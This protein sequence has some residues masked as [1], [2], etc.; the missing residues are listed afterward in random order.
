MLLLT[1]GTV[2]MFLLR[3]LCSQELVYIHLQVHVSDCVFCHISVVHRGFC[4]R[5]FVPA[6]DFLKGHRRD[7]LLLNQCPIHGHM[8]LYKVK[9]GC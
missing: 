5:M 4:P 9:V 6:E 2:F 7:K 8:D 1:H 3:F